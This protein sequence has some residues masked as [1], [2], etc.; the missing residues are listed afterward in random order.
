MSVIRAS[1]LVV[2]IT[3][4]QSTALTIPSALSRLVSS[5][6]TPVVVSGEP[7]RPQWPAQ[8]QVGLLLAPMVRQHCN[9]FKA[10]AHHRTD[11]Q[12]VL[13]SFPCFVVR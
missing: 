11:H 10:V 1:M 12:F 7:D 5:L 3:L 4:A 6:A 2:L 8:Y 9:L 13:L